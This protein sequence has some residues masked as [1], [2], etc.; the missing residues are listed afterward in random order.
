MP[1]S[2]RISGIFEPARSEDV[3]FE[4]LIPHRVRDILVV[5]S[6]Y[7]A[8]ILEEGGHLTELV[9]N[10]YVNLNLSDGPRV[11]RVDSAEEALRNLAVVLAAVE[12]NA[13]QRPVEVGSIL[14][15]G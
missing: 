8:F 13:T 7:D 11:T 14:G 2:T 15:D 10:E 9:L 12:A 6:A 3:S 5:A 1:D 4:R